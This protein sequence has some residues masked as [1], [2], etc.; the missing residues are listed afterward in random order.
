MSNGS[1]Q[2]AGLSS[3]PVT[4]LT[5]QAP[6][7]IDDAAVTRRESRRR[8]FRVRAYGDRVFGATSLGLA[9]IVLLLIIAITAQ[10]VQASLP[11]IKAFGLGFLVSSDWDPVN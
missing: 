8:E 7:A 11:S 6:G 9:L 1:A 3:K 4:V 10:L 2:E 5:D